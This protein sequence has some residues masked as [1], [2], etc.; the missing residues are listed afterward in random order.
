VVQKDHI[1]VQL[2]FCH[3]FRAKRLEMQADLLNEERFH[4]SRVVKLVGTFATHNPKLWIFGIFENWYEIGWNLWF[5]SKIMKLFAT[6]LTRDL[7]LW[8]SEIGQNI[9][10]KSKIV[11]IWNISKILILGIFRIFVIYLK[12]LNTLNIW[13]IC[14]IILLKYCRQWERRQ[15][16]NSWVACFHFFSSIAAFLHTLLQPKC[17]RKHF[18]SSIG[19]FFHV[20]LQPKC[21]RKQPLQDF[22]PQLLLFST[23]CC[24]QNVAEKSR[25]KTFLFKCCFFPRFVATKMWPKTLFLLN[26]C[27]FPHFVET[28]TWP[29]TAASRICRS[30]NLTYCRLQNF[31]KASWNLLS[32]LQSRVILIAPPKVELGYT[33]TQIHCWLNVIITF[34]LLLEHVYSKA[35][36]QTKNI[37]WSEVICNNFV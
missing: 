35:S 6:F 31:E 28:E 24:N 2:Y 9:R 13:D 10:C 23:L 15:F 18:F 37:Y 3:R 29:K 7:K 27:F 33:W 21:V 16:Q 12:N 36:Q 25:F 34:R 22:S 11:N 20:L 19:A 4:V 8:N 1:L 14:N 5:Q 32:K 26:C 30:W 17:D